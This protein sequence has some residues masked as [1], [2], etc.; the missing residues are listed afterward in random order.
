MQACPT[1]SSSCVVSAK[2]FVSSTCPRR[3]SPRK[4]CLLLA[5]SSPSVD[6]RSASSPGGTVTLPTIGEKQVGS[7]SGFED[8]QPPKLQ[9]ISLQRAWPHVLLCHYSTLTWGVS[10]YSIHSSN[11]QRT[12]LLLWTV[13]FHVAS[14]DTCSS[15]ICVNYVGTQYR[16]LWCF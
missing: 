16:M 7:F 12:K 3:L 1:W 8:V 10:C 15:Q 14:S 5:A 4:V 2:V 13:Q 9:M 6:L 11:P